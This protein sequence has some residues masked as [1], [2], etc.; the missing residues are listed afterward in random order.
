[1]SKKISNIE[2]RNTEVAGIESA[3]NGMRNPLKSHHISDSR[4]GEGGCSLGERDLDLAIKLTKAGN[5]HRKFLR[6]IQVWA[7]IKLPRFIWS[8]FDTYQ[9]ITKNS[10]STMHTIHRRHIE[11]RDFYQHINENHLKYLNNI[12]DSKKNGEL[13]TIEFINKI[14]NE[15]PD[16]YL[17]MRTINTN[18]EQLLNMYFQRRGHKLKPWHEVCNWIESLP[19][20]D[21]FINAMEENKNK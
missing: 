18:Y 5:E 10:E 17:Q 2:I 12:I 4:F 21:E 15:L 19:Y 6:M 3:F 8:E 1:M 11:Q 7:D 14:K 9:F 13:T 20:M 16:G